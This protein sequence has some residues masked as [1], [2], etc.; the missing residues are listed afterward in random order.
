MKGADK[1]PG[2]IVTFY[3]YKGGTG[4][5]MAV[6]N[7][8]WILASTG[9]KVLVIDWDLEAPGLHRY[10]RPFLD[11]KELTQSP[12]LIDFFVDFAAAGRVE[13]PTE[14]EA[15]DTPPWYE[16]YTD[17]LRYAYAV[18]WSPEP[19]GTT[20]K[21]APKF[22]LEFV[23]AGRQGPGYA[24]NVASFDWPAF[25]DKL[26]GGVF[27]EA[28][29]R[30]LRATYDYVLID[31]RT[32]ISDTSGICT[33]QMPDDLV[34]CFTLNRQSIVGAAAVVESAMGQRRRATGEPSL[35]V[36]PVP[37]RVELAEKDRLDVARD[38]ARA[39]FQKYLGH[40]TKV[41]RAAYWGRAE[42]IYYP[43]FA[44]EEVLASFAERR[45]Q[46]NSLLASM[47]VLA[48][49]LTPEPVQLAQMPEGARREGLARFVP[50]KPSR[51][52]SG[53][54]RP[55]RIY[56]SYSIEDLTSV[57]R[58]VQRL[59]ERF[60]SAVWWDKRSLLPG[61]DWEAEIT[62]AFE[63]AD[64]VLSCFG[65]WWDPAREGFFAKETIAL[66]QQ[67]HRHVIPVLLDGIS[68][69]SWIKKLGRGTESLGRRYAATIGSSTISEDVERLIAG[70]ERLLATTAPSIPSD[71]ED[72]QKG[73]WGGAPSRNGR[74][75]DASVREIS[76]GWFEV[77]LT[78]SAMPGGASLDGAVVF[79]LH[80][81]CTEPT[82][83]IDVKDGVARL[84]LNLWGSF[85][86]GAVA[87]GGGT[88]LELDLSQNLSYPE[89]FRNR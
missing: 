21:D 5:S 1:P 25:Y 2:R 32:G 60:G 87:D 14:P 34:V 42:V 6:A 40:L 29:K 69:E 45:G 24:I 63:S 10:F 44:Y 41:D 8:A 49:R 82:K 89:L 78:V 58:L 30:H 55:K 31:S 68:A 59:I 62:R 72:P 4:R 35:T 46:T 16:D 43:Y 26:G 74:L 79:H 3:S 37:M 53:A 13:R 28:V 77:T 86:V 15:G 19:S 88:T 76:E 52:A 38:L 66:S 18:N 54:G 47:E 71:P 22:V 23:P 65:I 85:T 64:V 73:Q 70:I 50:P 17:L 7:V 11:D 33:V 27:L 61:A 57:Q 39:T 84:A 51:D 75:L 20:S 81:T 67:P 36:W 48:S 56:V 83:T 9:L 80:P 12:G